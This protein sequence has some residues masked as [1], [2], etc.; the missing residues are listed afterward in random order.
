M[1]LFACPRDP[2]AMLAVYST[3]R[4]GH[5]HA[6]ATDHLDHATSANATV[7]WRGTVRIIEI[8]RQCITAV[9]RFVTPRDKP[10]N[11]VQDLAVTFTMFCARSLINAAK[12]PACLLWCISLSPLL[13]LALLCMLGPGFQ[14]PQQS[15]FAQTPTFFNVKSWKKARIISQRSLYHWSTRSEDARET[16]GATVR[17]SSGRTPGRNS[18]GAVDSAWDALKQYANDLRTVQAPSASH[19]DDQV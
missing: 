10:S 4:D 14:R 16:G 5:S 15:R 11:S 13:A 6:H 3:Y 12:R 19:I 18:E 17:W 9:L 2:E 7:P 8:L 1:L